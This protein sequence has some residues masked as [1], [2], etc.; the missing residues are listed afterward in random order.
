[1]VMHVK[2]LKLGYEYARFENLTNII[3]FKM[4]VINIARGIL[5][6]IMLTRVFIDGNKKG[7]PP[8]FS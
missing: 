2:N 4:M 5:N 1:M 7:K 6:A 8:Q 3:R